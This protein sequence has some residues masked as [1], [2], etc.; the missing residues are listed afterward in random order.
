MI[1][2]ENWGRIPWSLVGESVFR[3]TT[4]V[5]SRIGCSGVPE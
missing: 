1:H 2:L 3:T 5:A 4:L